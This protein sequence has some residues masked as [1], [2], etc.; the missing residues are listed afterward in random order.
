[1]K[2]VLSIELRRFETKLADLLDKEEKKDAPIVSSNGAK[3]APRAYNTTIKNYCK[4]TISHLEQI[5]KDLLF[6]CSLGPI[7]QVC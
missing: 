7:W 4:L 2:S 3:A 1:M 5:G 6:I